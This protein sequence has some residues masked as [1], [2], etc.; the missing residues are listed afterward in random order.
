MQNSF[1]QGCFK[2]VSLGIGW[3]AVYLACVWPY[4][5]YIAMT[6]N[7]I[8]YENEGRLACIEKNAIYV[9]AAQTTI[10]YRIISYVYTAG[11]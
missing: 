2:G 9:N 11:I 5:A 8:D 4:M 10:F 7:A 6:L 3:C 1:C